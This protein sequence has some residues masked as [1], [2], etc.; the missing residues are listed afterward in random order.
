MYT[1]VSQTSS[2]EGS[3]AVDGY[4]RAVGHRQHGARYSVVAGTARA[5]S[6]HGVPGEL[7][8][9][10]D[11]TGLTTRHQCAVLVEYERFLQ[12]VAVHV[13][14][15]GRVDLAVSGQASSRSRQ[16]TCCTYCHSRM[17][18]G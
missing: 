10:E 18:A 8:V 3:E 16:L 9:G 12:T 13:H 11:G 6:V 15:V 2:D 17:K 5:V 14:A 4:T 1:C 7:R